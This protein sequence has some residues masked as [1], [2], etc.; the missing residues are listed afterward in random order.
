MANHAVVH[1]EIG[2]PDR[3]SLLDFYGKLFGWTIS[4]D[5]PMNYAIVLK[6]DNGIGGGIMQSPTGG[7]YCTFYVTCGD[8]VAG[9]LAK[10]ESL[11][12]TKT[13]DVMDV[14]GG[15]TIAAFQDPDGN[16]IGLVNGN[17]DEEP[18]MTGGGAPVTWFEIGAKDG[19]KL[20]KFY[21]DL[22]GWKI[23]A[24]NPMQY[25]MT[26][27]IGNGIGG[28]IGSGVEEPYVTIYVAVPDLKAT[29]DRAAELGG[30]TVMEPADVP[31]GPTIAQFT[32]VAGNVIGLLVP[33]TGQAG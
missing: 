4:A 26:D 11:G 22:F 3:R 10:A 28:G 2:G 9:M 25:G 21:G 23:D 27:A 6:M 5:N 15:P 32:D 31:G 8:D 14:E 29:L 19:S 12:A 17:A 16:F 18:P 1:F 7:P 13:M 20:Q 24:D 33:N 30:K